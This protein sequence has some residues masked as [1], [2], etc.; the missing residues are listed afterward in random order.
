MPMGRRRRCSE[1]ARLFQR[2]ARARFSRRLPRAVNAISRR[3]PNAN[4]PQH[5]LGRTEFS[6]PLERERVAASIIAHAAIQLRPLVLELEAGDDLGTGFGCPILHEVAGLRVALR[7]LERNETVDT[8][9]AVIH[10]RHPRPIFRPLTRRARHPRVFS[11]RV[12]RLLRSKRCALVLFQSQGIVNAACRLFGIPRC[13][14]AEPQ[15]E[16]QEPGKRSGQPRK[17]TTA[18]ARILHGRTCVRAVMR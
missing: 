2:S 8:P 16:E 9:S 1:P 13:K 12:C 15:R 7:I 10:A 3:C 14:M 17:T 18:A 6:S 11:K 5:S 4:S